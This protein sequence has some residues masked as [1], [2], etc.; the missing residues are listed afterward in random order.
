MQDSVITMIRIMLTVATLFF[1]SGPVRNWQDAAACD[2]DAFARY[3]RGMLE[4]GFLIAPSQYEALFVSTAHT[5]EEI[6]SF[7]AAAKEVLC[8]L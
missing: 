6:D 3:F 2:T 4:R 8:N 1:T 5:E 7:T